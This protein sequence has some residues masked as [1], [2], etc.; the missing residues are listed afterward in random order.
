ME[1]KL[2]SSGSTYGCPQESPLSGVDS[3][4]VRYIRLGWGVVIAGIGGF[5]LWASLAPLDKGV[6]LS[7]TVT[8]A[9]SRKAIQHQTGGTIEDIFVK[10]G[11]VVDAGAVLVRMNSVQVK[12][13][14]ETTRVQY[15]AKRNTGLLA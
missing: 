11:D 8:V 12:A 10:D 3:D 9:T 2:Q 5:L 7:G 14:A 6:P 1:M 4:A 13:N 15:F